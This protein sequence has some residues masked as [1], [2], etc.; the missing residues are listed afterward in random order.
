MTHTP[1]TQIRALA[2]DLLRLIMSI[3]REWG[4]VGERGLKKP[5]IIRQREDDILGTRT[6]EKYNITR[7]RQRE[8]KEVERIT[9]LCYSIYGATESGRRLA[10]QHG[11]LGKAL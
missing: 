5:I 10:L 11:G 4:E 7:E 8:N 9:S 2:R 6:F 1:L 3:I